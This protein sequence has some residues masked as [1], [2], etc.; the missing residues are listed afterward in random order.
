MKSQK[1][2]ISPPP[3]KTKTKQN[4]KPPPKKTKKTI[5]TNQNEQN[6]TKR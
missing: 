2:G 6:K 3:K 5:K 4:R 1:T